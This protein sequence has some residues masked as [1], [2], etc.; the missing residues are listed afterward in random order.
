MLV[1]QG[2]AVADGLMAPGTFRDPIAALLLMPDE[3][4]AV[5]RARDGTAPSDL[6]DRLA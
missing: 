3:R 2:R 4:A 1:C 6:R 5:E